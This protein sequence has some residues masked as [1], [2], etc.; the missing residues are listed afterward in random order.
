MHPRHPALLT[1]LIFNFKYVIRV[2]YFAVAEVAHVG[3]GVSIVGDCGTTLKP[4]YISP[5][6]KELLQC[7][8]TDST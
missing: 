1:K 5:L 4:L 6:S 3:S 7:P 2:T 8:Q